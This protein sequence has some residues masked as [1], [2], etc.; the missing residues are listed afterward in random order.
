MNHLVQEDRKARLHVEAGGVASA[1]PEVVW[2]LVAD[3][4]SY[5]QWGAWSAS[6]YSDPGDLAH[7]GVGAVRWFRFGRT[8]TVER[9]LTAERPRRLTYTVVS[10]IPVRNYL[11]EVTLAPHGEGTRIHWAADWDATLLGRIV[12]RR[13]R[14]FYPDMVRRLISAAE[15]TVASSS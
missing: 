2:D 5:S 8:I 3:A 13:L 11:A 10:G 6:G 15:A 9:V 12:H 14:T 1:A 4:S 7:E